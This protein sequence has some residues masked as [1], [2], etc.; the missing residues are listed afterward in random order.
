[1]LNVNVPDLAV[2]RLA[3]I[4]RAPLAT[5]GAV[6]AAARERVDE[7][8]TAEFRVSQPDPEPGSDA[9]LLR[10]GWV[11]VTALRSVGAD[12]DVDAAPFIERAV[13]RAA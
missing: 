10:E 7:P 6:Q 5:F 13:S 11:T 3:G 4:R 2:D 1:V 8:F 9:A 12:D